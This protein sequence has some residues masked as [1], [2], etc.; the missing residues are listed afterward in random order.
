VTDTSTVVADDEIA[1]DVEAERGGAAI[2]RVFATGPNATALAGKRVLI[3]SIDP[4]GECD[5]CR[6]G[7]TAV[8]PRLRRRTSPLGPRATAAA[9]WAI[10]L[11]ED[12]GVDLPASGV[13]AGA[14]VAIAYTLYARTGIGPREPTVVVGASAVATALVQVL[15]AKGIDA[16]HVSGTTPLED[17]RAEVT[18]K[19][20][21]Q[22]LGAK[23]W[24]VIATTAADAGLAAALCGARSTLTVLSHPDSP[25]HPAD[26]V[27]REVA[28]IPVAG[29]HPD[30]YVEAI[31]LVMQGSV[32]AS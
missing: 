20:A 16:A 4:C 17:L 21:E 28:V 25:A 5:V 9:R 19:F 6:R 10:V 30:L 8:C 13:S 23:P 2:G 14:D 24:R 11:G 29:P 15:S 26:L 18:A 12:G 31:A 32:G 27:A 3:G 7:G 1:I 22:G